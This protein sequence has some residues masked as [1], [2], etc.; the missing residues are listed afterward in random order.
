MKSALTLALLALCACGGSSDNLS[1][2]I[3]KTT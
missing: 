2:A 3:G 1:S